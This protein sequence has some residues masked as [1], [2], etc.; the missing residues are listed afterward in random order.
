MSAMLGG[1]SS[2]Q[3]KSCLN[4]RFRV[5][6]QGQTSS[7]W[8]TGSVCVPI[9][10]VV[11]VQQNRTL[12]FILSWSILIMLHLLCLWD[13]C[14]QCCLLKNAL[15]HGLLSGRFAKAWNRSPALG[16]TMDW[17]TRSNG[18]PFAHVLV[19]AM[20]K[21]RPLTMA[22]GHIKRRRFRLQRQ[23]NYLPNK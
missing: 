10:L 15:H 1:P 18:R 11:A 2:R 12:A 16:R 3:D 20:T 14:P 5:R 23:T 6:L 7:A 4:V 8:E 22:N 13:S 21:R 9:A 19:V 17:R